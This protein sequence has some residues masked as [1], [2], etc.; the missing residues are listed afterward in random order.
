M[1]K[2]MYHSILQ[3]EMIPSAAGLFPGSP[4]IFQH[5]NDPKHKARINQTYLAN[6]GVNV[7][8][9]PAQSPDLN[10][11]ENLWNH[12][13]RHLQNRD[14]NNEEELFNALKGG[15][16]SITAEYV[17]KLVDSMPNRC[18]AVIAANGN[19]TKY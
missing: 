2:E 11:I 4:W 19:G 10:P 13:D 3:R 5:D 15:W 17:E 12:L 1:D 18:A 16:E 6:I 9:W 14:C 8:D 7:L